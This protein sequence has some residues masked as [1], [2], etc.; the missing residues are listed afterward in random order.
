MPNPQPQPAAGQHSQ[1]DQIAGLVE[2]VTFHNDESGFCVLRIKARG[3]R[4]L[5]TVIGTLPEV[6]AGEWLEAQGAWIIDKE[7]GQQFRAEFLRTMPPT[8]VEGIEKYL[9]SGMIKGIDAR[10]NRTGPELQSFMM[11]C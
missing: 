4:E 7:Y 10:L 9:A 11:V 5:V 1:P 6:R 2:R 8:T 3:H